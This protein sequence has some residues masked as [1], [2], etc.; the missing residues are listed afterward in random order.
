MASRLQGQNIPK[1]LVCWCPGSD[2]P[3]FWAGFEPGLSSTVTMPELGTLQPA[4]K[5]LNSGTQEP[6]LFF[7]RVAHTEPGAA[8]SPT[9]APA[10][11]AST[12]QKM[13]MTSISKLG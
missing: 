9:S 4:W 8:A 5:C 3:A 13:N 1:Q 2:H 7:L 10:P 12:R 6:E 11:V